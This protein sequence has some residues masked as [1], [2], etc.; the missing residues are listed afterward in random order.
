MKSRSETKLQIEPSGLSDL[1]RWLGHH[2]A[3]VLYE[4]R[5]VSSMYFD[6]PSLQMFRET[7]QG[8]TPRHKLRIRCYGRHTKSCGLI[9]FAEVKRT[10]IE[11]RSKS[12][13]Q[14]T[15][16]MHLVQS[17]WAAS[18]YGITLPKLHVSYLRDYFSVLGVRLTI[19]REIEYSHPDLSGPAWKEERIAVEVKAP[20][21]INPDWE[22]NA[23]P[24]PRHHFSKYERGMIWLGASP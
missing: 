12:S 4:P 23:F 10:S 13:E 1:Y 9:H 14:I 3:K 19:D 17:G 21:D 20:P 2:S 8:L 11:G 16:W 22:A 15:P 6:T 24:F 7:A 18:D 5:R